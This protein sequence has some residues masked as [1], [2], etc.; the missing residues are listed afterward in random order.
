MPPAKKGKRQVTNQK[1]LRPGLVQRDLYGSAGPSGS[2]CSPTRNSGEDEGRSV[3][4][5]FA[6]SVADIS[7]RGDTPSLAAAPA[8]AMDVQQTQSTN[9]SADAPTLLGQAGATAAPWQPGPDRKKGNTD[10]EAIALEFERAVQEPKA[11]EKAHAG[12]AG[13]WQNQSV[14]TTDQD[15][16]AQ[17]TVPDSD[18]ASLGLSTKDTAETVSEG[19]LEA[20]TAMNSGVIERRLQTGQIS[21]A[22]PW[23]CP[24]EVERTP[25]THGSGS[26]WSRTPVTDVSQKLL[27]EFSEYGTWMELAAKHAETQQELV[28]TR[29]HVQ[30]YAELLQKREL[31]GMD[32][33]AG[34]GGASWTPHEAAKEEIQEYAELLLK[35]QR[36]SHE[37]R[38]YLKGVL[39]QLLARSLACNSSTALLAKSREELTASAELLQKERLSTQEVQ[40]ELQDT[41]EGL[42]KALA[43]NNWRAQEK[44]RSAEFHTEWTALQ[45]QH[46]VLEAVLANSQLQHSESMCEENG[47][48]DYQ[49]PNTWHECHSA[50]FLEVQSEVEQRDAAVAELTNSNHRTWQLEDQL[51]KSVLGIDSCRQDISRLEHKLFESEKASG[52]ALHEWQAVSSRASEQAYEAYAQQLDRKDD[53]VA[54]VMCELRESEGRLRTARIALHSKADPFRCCSRLFGFAETPDFTAEAQGAL[55]WPPS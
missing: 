54:D 31:F 37:A 34:P 25:A 49:Q 35:E 40:S 30:Q 14:Y 51:N 50:L 53:E 8:A 23:R 5:S 28:Q 29:A 10:E 42:A 24:A 55:P 7:C 33:Q 19:L 16:E 9:T 3:C 39:E 26:P 17:D 18:F 47:N 2:E 12:E 22:P 27:D 44:E 43:G 15:T 11:Q 6:A 52:W 20:E 21:L 36:S 1:V 41:R 4:S 48:K 32:H 13:T 38:S 45:Q 46:V